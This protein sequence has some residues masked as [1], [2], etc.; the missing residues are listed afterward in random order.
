MSA[1]ATVVTV[2][3]ISVPPLVIPIISGISGVLTGVSSAF[4]IKDLKSK[5]EKKID[6]IKKIKNSIDEIELEGEK[7]W[8]KVRDIVNTLI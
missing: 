1:Q 7:N 8:E 3:T 5:I 4:K 2:S 6:E